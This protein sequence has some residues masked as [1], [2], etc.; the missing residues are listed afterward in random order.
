MGV[1]CYFKHLRCLLLHFIHGQKQR[2]KLLSLSLYDRLE[3]V[4]RCLGV[5]DAEAR[6]LWSQWGAAGWDLEC[7]LSSYGEAVCEFYLHFVL[8][9]TKI[10]LF[11]NEKNETKGGRHDSSSLETIFIVDVQGESK[12]R[13]ESRPNIAALLNPTMRRERRRESKRGAT[14][15]E[16]KRQVWAI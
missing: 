7:G 15:Q 1:L 16:T 5:K 6:F 9:L 4:I 10:Y 3:F 14:D 2:K 12:Q 13:E 11:M 8:F